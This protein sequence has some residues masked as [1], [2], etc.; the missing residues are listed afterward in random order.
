[1]NRSIVLG[2][3]SLLLLTAFTAGARTGRETAPAFRAEIAGDV[4]GRPSGD[5]RFGITGGSADAPTTF[6]IALGAEG[7]EGAILFTR[8]SGARLLPGTYRISDRADGSDDIR[9]LVVT[10]SATHPT[11]VFHGTSGEVVVTS[12]TEQELRGTFRI[13]AR[14]FLAAEPEVEGRPVRVSGSF[15]AVR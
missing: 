14:G 8:Q 15:A 10:G 6:T 4:T 2:L 7:D 1:M 9:A 3:G 13:E 12:A 11:G 5:A